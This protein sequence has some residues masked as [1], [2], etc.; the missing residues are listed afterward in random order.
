MM[1]SEMV[2]VDGVPFPPEV[3]IAKPLPLLGHGITD[4]EIHFLQIKYNAIGIYMEKNIVE[5]LGNWK[6]KKGAELAEDDLFF[7]A[8]AAA[9]VDKIFR[10]VVIKEI[11]GS[12]YGV[13]LESAVRDRLAAIDKYEEEEEEALEKVSEFFQ[14]KYF[15]KDSVIT[16]SFPATPRTAEI[17]FV[18]EGKEQTKIKVENA[19]VVEMIQKWYLGGSTSV[20]PTTVKSLAENLGAILS[21]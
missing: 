12:Q 4:I 10:I 20:S 17:S 3:T 2:M 1:G 8:L 9:P 7:E 6:G 16:F 21:Q 11:K 13:Q 5:H 19:N 14:T 15:K 18:T